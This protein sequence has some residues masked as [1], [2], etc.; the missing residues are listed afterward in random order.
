MACAHILMIS[1]YANL[2]DSNQASWQWSM[3]MLAVVHVR[4]LQ[5]RE[6]E[7]HATNT[8]HLHPFQAVFGLGKYS[9]ILPPLSGYLPRS[10]KVNLISVLGCLR[11]SLGPRLWWKLLLRKHFQTQAIDN[12]TSWSSQEPKGLGK[13]MGV[14]K[15]DGTPISH[16][17]MIMFSRENA[18][19]LGST[20]LGNLHMILG[21][22]AQI[23]KSEL[24]KFPYE[25]TLS[26]VTLAEVAI[27]CQ[28][29]WVITPLTYLQ[30]VPK[31]H[32]CSKL[33]KC[34]TGGFVDP[35]WLSTSTSST[36]LSANEVYNNT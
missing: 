11:C 35:M 21:K 18:W 19:L 27:I 33:K 34:G 22:L 15:N 28:D 10:I 13:D 12:R 20:T 36:N 14:A 25:S 7:A 16:P 31:Q 3:F 23:P 17:K 30:T 26:G 2:N 32:P 8:I 24:L 1:L 29:D 4:H 6:K 9:F 5:V